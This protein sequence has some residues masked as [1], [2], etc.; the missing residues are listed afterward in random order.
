MHLLS[1]SSLSEPITVSG[2]RGLEER[3]QEEHIS[4][5]ASVRF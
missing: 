1:K 5:S 2:Q 3:E 4:G